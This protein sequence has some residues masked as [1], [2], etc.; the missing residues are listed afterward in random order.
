MTVDKAPIFGK[1]RSLPKRLENLIV[2]PLRK[3]LTLL[4]NIRLRWKGLPDTNTLAY[5]RK[6]VVY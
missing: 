4:E 6:F 1:A 3:A 2:A 5:F